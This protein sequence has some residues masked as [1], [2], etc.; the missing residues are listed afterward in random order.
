MLS[1]IINCPEKRSVY[2]FYIGNR[3]VGGT[4]NLF[5]NSIGH[6]YLFNCIGSTI[7]NYNGGGGG[8]KDKDD[9]KGDGGGIV[10]N[11]L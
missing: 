2:S 4:G 8:D 5:N 11:D 6:L 9:D 1:N 7:G 10:H 3:N